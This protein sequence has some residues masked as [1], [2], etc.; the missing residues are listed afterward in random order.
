MKNIIKLIGG[1]VLVVAIGVLPVACAGG[2]KPAGGADELDAAIREASN[3]FNSRIPRGSKVAFIN[4]SG[5]YPDL[6]DYI[7]SDLSKHGVNDGVFSVV[8]RAQLEQVRAELNFNLS[9]EVSDQSAQEIGRMLGAQTIVSGSVRKIGSLYRLDVKAIEVQTASI[10]GQWN[11]NIPNGM[12]IAALTENTASGSSTA[13]AS[14]G[15]TQEIT[16]TFVNNTGNTVTSMFF[17]P[18]DSTDPS[19]IQHFSFRENLGNRN[20]RRVTLPPLD[21]TKRYTIGLI[22][23]INDI[24]SKVN[25]S[26]LQNKTITLD[27]SD[28]FQLPAQAAASNQNQAAESL[29]AYRIGD[30]GPAGGLIFYDKGNNSGGWRYL[31]AAPVEAEFQAVMSVRNTPVDNLQLTIGSGRQNTKLIVDKYG[32]TTGEWDTAAQKCN[33]LVFNGFNDWFLPSQAELDLIYGQLKRKNTGDF[34]NEW[35]WSSSGGRAWSSYILGSIQN[36]TD[37]S[38]YFEYS[39]G[40]HTFNNRNYV[41]PIRQVPGPAR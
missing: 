1:I 29:P 5:G 34:K 20:S 10:Q 30:T 38:I 12:T 39:S 4:I 11:R 22:D 9:G 17:Y 13:S 19:N 25:V 21:T 31:E 37:G 3:Y 18:L 15:R 40:R 23:I 28:K 7:L 2:P 8:D 26:L 24:Y 32:Q 27:S 6:A 16:I 36:F 14:S 41:R 33:D 35:Y